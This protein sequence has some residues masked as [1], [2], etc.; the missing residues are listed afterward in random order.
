MNQ[1]IP[2]IILFNVA[3]S[4]IPCNTIRVKEI[5][6][7]N[8]IGHKCMVSLISIDIKNSGNPKPRVLQK[9]PIA[10]AQPL[11]E[12]AIETNEIKVIPCPAMKPHNYP[13][14]AYQYEYENPVP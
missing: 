1:F 10:A 6:T 12:A 7:I 2:A 4:S 9:P 13:Y 11:E 5:M 8:D 14:V 3:E